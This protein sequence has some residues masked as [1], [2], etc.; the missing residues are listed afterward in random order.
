MKNLYF[1]LTAVLAVSLL[2]GTVVMS[3]GAFNL[4]PSPKEQTELGITSANVVCKTG[5]SLI[6]R[7]DSETPACVKSSSSEKL[8]QKGWAINLS[9]LL[10]KN[11][12]LSSIGQVKTLQVVPLYKDEGI[13][14]TKPNI[15]LNYNF[16]FEACA[17]SSLIRSPEI[18]ITTDSETKTVKL[19]QQIAPQSCQISSTVIKATDVNSIKANL[20]K[21]TDL[22]LM[23]GQL[24]LRVSELKEKLATEKKY[25]STISS[26]AL[27][28]E[29][30]QKKI[31][32]T[33]DKIITLRNELNLAKAELQKNQYSLLLGSKL[34][35][36]IKV[37]LKNKIV[38]PFVNNTKVNI[39]HVNPIE[40]IKKYSDAGRLKTDA[41]VSSYNFVLEVCAGTEQIQYPE[42]LVKSDSEIKSIKLSESLD[43]KS[44]Q[45]TSTVIKAADTKT[46]E[47]LIVAIGEIPNQIKALE[48]KV[49]S[50]KEQLSINKQALAD[51]VTQK[52]VPDDLSKKVSELTAKVVQQRDELNQA[53]EELINLKYL[54]AE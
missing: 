8:I 2:S 36:P 3:Y 27:T 40:I 7:A 9:T 18:L 17:K 48:F 29:N 52:P 53:R 54:V 6:I 38:I 46:I 5:L 34:P 42:I 4:I 20:V 12:N 39:P 51:L 47:G 16:V 26:Q 30:F 24:E 35:E 32:E 11:P 10:E 28:P 21:K 23:V 22:S 19:S 50:L 45:T 44:C 37:P 14:Q 13:Q 43:P 25:L 33:T 15:I 1:L 49:E 41:I 31:S